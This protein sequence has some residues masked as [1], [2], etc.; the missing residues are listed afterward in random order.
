MKTFRLIGKITYD[1]GSCHDDRS[2]EI[3]REIQAINENEAIEK[4][5]KISQ[6]LH[7][8]YNFQTDYHL[9][10]ELKDEKEK[11]IWR[12]YS[13]ESGREPKTGSVFHYTYNLK[14]KTI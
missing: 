13:E 14:E 10:L 2:V 5:R 1:V 12:I 7:V 6:E 8:K 11:V 4:A 3:N 9:V